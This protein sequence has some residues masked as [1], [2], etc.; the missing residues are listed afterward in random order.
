MSEEKKD[1]S[2][3]YCDEA[4]EEKL[5]ELD[6]LKQSL[7]EK[8]KK[9]EEYYDQLLRLK[10][11]FENYRKRTERDK[12]SH[13]MWGKEE[14][15]LKQL[16]ILDIL[17]QAHKSAMSSTNIEAVQKGLELIIQEFLKMTSSE[18]VSEI[19]CLGKTFDPALEEAVDYIESNAKEGTVVEV[20]QKGYTSKQKLLRPAKVRVAKKSVVSD[21]R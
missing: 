19:E 21:K 18:G 6:I 2:K 3:D 20:L 7:D 17:E 11:D 15:L 13:M 5:S 9:A 1:A 8:R 10:A 14:M 16:G 4:R 12:H